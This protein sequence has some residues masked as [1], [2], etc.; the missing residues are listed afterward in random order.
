M[1]MTIKPFEIS[2]RDIVK[3]YLNNEEEG[4][5]AFNGK[6]NIRPK[7]QREF[8]YN[9]AKRN[10]VINTIIKGYPLNVMYWVKNEDGTF[11]MLDGQQRTISFCEF[12]DGNFSIKYRDM[13]SSF[14]GL[15]PELQIKI[16][17]YKCQIYICENGTTEEKLDWFQIINI[18]GEVLTPQELRNAFYTG[19]WLTSAK[20]MFSKT[21][22]KAYRIANVY[23]NGSCI[24]QEYLE[25]ALDWIS[26]GHI[27][28]YMNEHRSDSNANELWDYFEKVIG[29][30]KT[31]F[32]KYNKVMKGIEWGYLFNKY[33]K[34]KYDPKKLN[35]L[36]DKCMQDKEIDNKKGIY[37]YVFDGLEKHLNL[38]EF[39]DAD[40][41][42]MYARQKGMCPICKK[43]YEINEMEAHHIK[44]WC[45]GGKTEIRNGI[46]LCRECHHNEVLKLHH[47]R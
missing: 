11:E 42:T 36:V 21:N 27:K 46:M 32:P 3:G 7:Y 39:D 26:N 47:K 45:D 23:L 38:R 33:N 1:A 29:W 4:V 24:R 40:K 2:I 15:P 34:N 14:K 17:D 28:E 43:H 35:E 13:P 18:A 10:A 19:E 5:V 12:L 41:T 22:C 31:L 37:E 25:T 8:V 20:R 16:L 44:Q 9:E 30:V 6:L